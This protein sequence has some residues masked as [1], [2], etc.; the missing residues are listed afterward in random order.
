MELKG[1]LK[2]NV[3][4]DECKIDFEVK[5]KLNKPV[6]GI[7]EHYFTCSHCGKKY[8]SYYTNKNIRR[9]QTE[10]RHLYS[11]LSKPKSN[12]QQQKLLEKIN[13]LKAAMKV[14]MDQLRSIY[15]G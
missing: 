5:P 9:K 15:Q 14:E 7:E 2:M 4:C 12:E 3:Q 6:P 8:I 13:N 10:I 1:D 11:K